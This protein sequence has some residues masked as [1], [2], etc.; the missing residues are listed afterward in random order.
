MLWQTDINELGDKRLNEKESVIRLREECLA[1]ASVCKIDGQDE[2][3]KAERSAGPRM[4]YT[5]IISRIR[6]ENPQFYVKDGIPGNVALY[7]TVMNEEGIPEERYVG[8]I[9]KEWLPEYSHVILD[10]SHLPI[11]EIRG[12]RSVII[13]LVK[14]GVL[15]YKQA[16]NQFGEATGSRS[17]R[18]HQQLHKY[19]L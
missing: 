11:R 18:W 9:P 10:S 14:S 16:V 4:Y 13:A 8:G 1:E 12:W 2:L 7:A 17:T 3:E 19:K 15:T 6:K 5:E